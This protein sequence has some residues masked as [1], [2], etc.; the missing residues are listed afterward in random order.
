LGARVA[1]T[2]TV[3]VQGMKRNEAYTMAFGSEFAGPGL[4]TVETAGNTDGDEN[5]VYQRTIGAFVQESF[6]VNDVLFLSAGVRLD[7]HSSFGAGNRYHTYPT[8]SASYVA[9]D[10]LRLPS[11]FST[12][13]L[14]VAYGSAG[15]PPA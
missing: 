11:A 5:R 8:A 10:Q 1:A 2:T 3:G 7:G 9:S 15:K 12:L 13:R 4:S 6:D 14:R